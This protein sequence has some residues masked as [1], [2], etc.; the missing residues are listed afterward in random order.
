MADFLR[1]ENSKNMKLMEI[2]EEAVVQF[3]KNNEVEVESDRTP[4][5]Q[6]EFF[7]PDI[8]VDSLPDFQ[9]WVKTIKL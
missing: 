9:T 3:V 1:Y 7:T 8:S 4:P 5:D 6:M 2:S